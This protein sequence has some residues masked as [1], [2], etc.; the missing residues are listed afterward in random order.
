MVVIPLYD[1]DAWVDGGGL[2]VIVM[3]VSAEH[4]V[5]LV[6]CLLATVQTFQQ[7]ACIVRL[8]GVNKAF[9]LVHVDFFGQLGIEERG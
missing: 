6:W 9:G 5:P 3:E 8:V 4:V 2:E 1:V 7:S